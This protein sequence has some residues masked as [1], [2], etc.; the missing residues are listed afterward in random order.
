[1]IA[2]DRRSAIAAAWGEPDQ[3]LTAVL[4][5]RGC[6]DAP[7]RA[8]DLLA[9]YGSLPAVLAASGVE[10]WRIGG[11][12]VAC[13]LGALGRAERRAMSGSMDGRPLIRNRAD[14]CSVVEDYAPLASENSI[15]AIILD[16]DWRVIRI[17]PVTATVTTSVVDIASHLSKAKDIGAAAL[18]VTQG[19]TDEVA[20]SIMR[21]NREFASSAPTPL[22]F[23]IPVCVGEVLL[24]KLWQRL[25]IHSA[26]TSGQVPRH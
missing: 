5:E 19:D 12:R 26:F 17:E 22:I 16:G 6:T 18:L 25:E 11:W 23:Q 2:H 8:L 1:M 9:H 4:Q 13:A 14:L 7:S 15:F 3:M 21:V 10:L 20:H 24:L